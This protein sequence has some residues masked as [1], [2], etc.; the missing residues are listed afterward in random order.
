MALG[1]L[2]LDPK[3][4]SLQIPHVSTP[5]SIF[6]IVFGDSGTGSTAQKQLAQVMLNYPFEFILHTGD[7]AYPRGTE[8]QIEDFFFNI[9]STHL[10]K[11][12][13]YPAPGNHDYLTDNLVPYL[14]KFNKPKYYSFDKSNIHFVSLDSNNISDEMLSWLRND[15][16]NSQKLWKMVYFHHPPYS[17]GL[18]HGEHKNVQETL[19]P[20]LEEFGADLVFSG[21]EHNYERSCKLSKGNCSKEGT[22]YVVT[23]GG[24]APIYWFGDV[25]NYSL[26]RATEHHFVHVEVSE[27]N[28]SA[29]A[30]GLDNQI[31]DKFELKKC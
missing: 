3:S 29:Q 13:F 28:L 21:H 30:I 10:K 15:L 6:F 2:F 20:I 23:G 22:T 25:K 26:S 9:Y 5:N 31:L 27:C 12:L 24:G 17:S 18:L 14:K 8:K 1:F 16:K 19:V 4:P 11:A 7:I